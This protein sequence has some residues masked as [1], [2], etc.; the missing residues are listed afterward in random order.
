MTDFRIGDL[1]KLFSLNRFHGKYGKIDKILSDGTVQVLVQ[2][3]T[4]VS[5]DD[6]ELLS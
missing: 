6:L 4:L 5:K 1:V 3:Y 2:E